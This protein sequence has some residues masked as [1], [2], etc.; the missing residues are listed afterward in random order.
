MNGNI[1]LTLCLLK[2][3]SHT[4]FIAEM[5]N[6]SRASLCAFLNIAFM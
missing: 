1:D 3:L 5:G 6:D 2:L 4:N